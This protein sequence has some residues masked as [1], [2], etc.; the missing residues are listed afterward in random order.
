MGR[1]GVSYG[2]G[3]RIVRTVLWG[4][5]CSNTDRI[6]GRARGT[7]EQNVG[8]FIQKQQQQPLTRVGWSSCLFVPFCLG[9]E[10]GAKSL[11]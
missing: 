8:P 10:G 9:S 6:E 7:R 5:L 4:W 11:F 2:S 3:P 1:T